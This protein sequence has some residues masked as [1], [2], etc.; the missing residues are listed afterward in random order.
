MIV[1][2]IPIDPNVPT[3]VIPNVT[4]RRGETVELKVSVKNNPGFSSAIIGIDYDTSRL[5]LMGVS[6]AEGIGGQF[7]YRTSAAWIDSSD[8]TADGDFIILTF[9]VK[10]DAEEGN[11]FVALIFEEGDISNYCEE[12]VN[13]AVDSKGINVVDYIPGDINGDGKVNSKDLTRLLKYL[14]GEAVEVVVPALDT[15]GD[16]KVNSKDLIRLLKYLSGENVELF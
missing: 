1:P 15:N 5:I 8:F 14:S 16:G 7:N 2:T 6:P 10:E 13:F 3:F 4:A 9:V 12:D 11:A